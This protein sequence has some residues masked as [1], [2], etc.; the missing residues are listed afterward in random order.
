MK[1]NIYLLLNEISTDNGNYSDAVLTEAELNRQRKYLRKY[2]V[3]RRKMHMAFAVAVFA[4]FSVFFLSAA[5][6]DRSEAAREY[7]LLHTSTL[8]G[9]DRSM[10]EYASKPKMKH[11]FDDITIIADSIVMGENEIVVSITE[12]YPPKYNVTRNMERLWS[13]SFSIPFEETYCGKYISPSPSYQ[14]E[15]HPDIP[16]ITSRL[17]VNGTEIL[18]N[19][20]GYSVGIEDGIIQSVHTFI[21]DTTNITFPADVRLELYNDVTE[22]PKWTFTLSLTKDNVVPLTKD[23]PL[24]QTITTPRGHDITFTRYTDSALGAKIYATFSEERLDNDG[25][26]YLSCDSKDTYYTLIG[27]SENVISPTESVF[28]LGKNMYMVLHELDSLSLY[29]GTLAPD[30]DER[31]LKTVTDNPLIIPLK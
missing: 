29:L 28:T 3:K 4:L 8:L 7:I 17:Y 24:N 14:Y 26:A 20:K 13:S 10:E 16:A 9:L 5:F 11:T 25:F 12:S 2:F 1:K 30:G 22:S 19:V 31:R 6:K 23:I 15:T 18:G 21:S 27:F